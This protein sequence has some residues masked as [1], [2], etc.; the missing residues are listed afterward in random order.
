M[1]MPPWTGS[2]DLA[3]KF[4]INKAKLK[5]EVYYDKKD[6]TFID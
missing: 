2:D 5:I 3:G 1:G 4:A 6:T